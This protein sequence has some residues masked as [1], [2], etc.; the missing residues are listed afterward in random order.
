MPTAGKVFVATEYM[1]LPDL[2]AA[3]EGHRVVEEYKE[4]DFEM[5]LITEV[6]NLGINEGVLT[7]LYIYDQVTHNYQRG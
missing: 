1:T 3:L 2:S 5:D 6:T 4:G 7:G